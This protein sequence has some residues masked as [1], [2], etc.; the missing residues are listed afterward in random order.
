VGQDMAVGGFDDI[1]LA[2]YASPSLTT[3]HQPIY[4]IGRRT[5]AML[6]ELVN[7]RTLDDPHVLLTPSLIIRASSGDPV[8]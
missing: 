7:G 3:V 1:P 2:A 8:S 5:C 6:I 4:D